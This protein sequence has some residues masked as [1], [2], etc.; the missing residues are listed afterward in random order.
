M[1][2]RMRVEGKKLREMDTG[3]ET[4]S[5]SQLVNDIHQLIRGDKLH[6]VVQLLLLIVEHKLDP[7]V[8]P[9]VRRTALVLLLDHLALPLNPHAGLV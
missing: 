8:A 9:E 7:V 6:P 3:K 5:V 4:E 1:Q 2:Q